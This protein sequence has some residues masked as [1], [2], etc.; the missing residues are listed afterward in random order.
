MMQG[1]DASLTYCQYLLTI[2]INLQRYI[3]GEIKYK[4]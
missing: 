1:K 4:T 3:M 2:K